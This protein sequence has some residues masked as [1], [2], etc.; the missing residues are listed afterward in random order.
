MPKTG[1]PCAGSAPSFSF[2][3]GDGVIKGRRGLCS[4][5]AGLANRA[6]V[7]PPL[8][9]WFWRSPVSEEGAHAWRLDVLE[10]SEA[11]APP[12]RLQMFQMFQMLWLPL[13]AVL[14]PGVMAIKRIESH[15]TPPLGPGAEDSSPEGLSSPPV[16]RL[17]VQLSSGWFLA[18]LELHPLLGGDRLD[19]S[20]CCSVDHVEPFIWQLEMTPAEVTCSFITQ[21]LRENTTAFLSTHNG[22]LT[23]P[24]ARCN[25]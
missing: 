17:E 2:Q 16:S 1:A 9:S 13:L 18:V 21:S 3:A 19:F 6:V 10:P 15:E 11:S 8:M 20:T 25:T 4:S 12:W 22:T 14:R 24:V 23:V 5:A 7:A